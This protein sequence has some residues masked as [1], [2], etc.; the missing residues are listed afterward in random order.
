MGIRSGPSK[1]QKLA[2][3]IRR[4]GGFLGQVT[5]R[6]MGAEYSLIASGNVPEG[7]HVT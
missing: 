5:W 1:R 6:E 3:I 4:E 7:F 2:A